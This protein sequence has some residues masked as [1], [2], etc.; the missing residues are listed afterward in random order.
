LT[1]SLGVGSPDLIVRSELESDE[2]IAIAQADH[3]VVVRRGKL[4]VRRG[5]QLSDLVRS[6]RLQMDFAAHVGADQV[7]DRSARAR[8]LGE[9]VVPA[10]EHKKESFL[11]GG[12]GQV[13][14]EVEA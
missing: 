11:P 3:L 7:S 2:W 12:A 4:D 1:Q 5:E 10:R 13:V 6:E 8:V 14:E 9:S